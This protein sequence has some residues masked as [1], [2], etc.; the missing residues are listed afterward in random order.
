MGGNFKKLALGLG[1]AAGLGASG[2]DDGMNNIDS[3]EIMDGGSVFIPDSDVDQETVDMGRADI[4]NEVDAV[5]D[6]DAEMQDMEMPDAEMEDMDVVEENEVDPNVQ[7]NLT[8]RK[9][10]NFFPVVPGSVEA[11][12]ARDDY[13]QVVPE[14][15]NDTTELKVLC[16]NI[17]NDADGDVAISPAIKTSGEFGDFDINGYVFGENLDRPVGRFSADGIVDGQNFTFL[18]N[19]VTYVIPE[20]ESIQVQSSFFIDGETLLDWRNE[21]GF[22]A[23][24]WLDVQVAQVQSGVGVDCWGNDTN[25]CNGNSF[26]LNN[27]NTAILEAHYYENSRNTVKY[28]AETGQQ[29]GFGEIVGEFQ[30]NG[31]LGTISSLRGL[32]IDC[33]GEDANWPGILGRLEIKNWNNN[34]NDLVLPIRSGSMSYEIAAGDVPVMSFNSTGI[35]LI[36]ENIPENDAQEQTSFRCTISNVFIENGDVCD[37]NIEN[38]GEVSEAWNLVSEEG[39]RIDAVDGH[40]QCRNTSGSLYRGNYVDVE[41]RISNNNAALNNVDE[42]SLVEYWC[43]TLADAA[44]NIG[45]IDQVSVQLEGKFFEYGIPM[46]VVVEKIDDA[47]REIVELGRTGVQFSPQ[48]NNQMTSVNVDFDP[49]D[50][51][52]WDQIRIKVKFEEGTNEI[53]DIADARNRFIQLERP[54]LKFKLTAI[55]GVNGEGDSIPV[56]LSTLLEDDEGDYSF[57]SVVLP[58]DFDGETIDGRR[59]VPFRSMIAPRP[60]G[61]CV[62]GNERV[63]RQNEEGPSTVYTGT[64][65]TLYNGGYAREL[66][67]EGITGKRDANGQDWLLRIGNDFFAMTSYVP[68]DQQGKVR[69]CFNTPDGFDQPEIRSGLVIIEEFEF[70]ENRN[71]VEVTVDGNLD[72]FNR[73]FRLELTQA[74]VYLTPEDREDM[75]MDIVTGPLD[76]DANGNFVYQPI[77]AE[78]SCPGPIVNWN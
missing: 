36:A 59:V 32:E 11:I 40:L 13:Y 52:Q 39:A 62:Q 55:R 50:I 76:L 27:E 5:V 51:A 60:Y 42:I 68:I 57:E 20:G 38:C 71:Q 69:I 48:N 65:N 3:P 41:D 7:G 16:V 22:H 34:A 64:I 49:V 26:I 15:I 17:T 14:G 4:G 35:L 19:G 66:C 1:L 73:Q 67:F 2:C 18:G 25:N 24:S 74:R 31:E 30:I 37:K 44:E 33:S 72:G 12:V 58:N 8:I 28:F 75:R 78:N 77:S 9:C 43:D 70:P 46:V 56:G 47:N 54:L 53:P 29:D 21:N 63:L 10:D 6:P 23:S 45:S 61:R